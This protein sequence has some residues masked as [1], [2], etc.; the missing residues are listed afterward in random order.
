MVYTTSPAH[1][2]SPRPTYH[3]CAGDILTPYL[4]APHSTS[5]FSSSSDPDV[6]S[7]T[8][9]PFSWAARGRLA[10]G[11]GDFL[12]RLHPLLAFPEKTRVT[13]FPL[14]HLTHM[15]GCFL[16]QSCGVKSFCSLRTPH[17]R[18]R[19][20]HMTDRA[21]YHHPSSSTSAGVSVAK[22][23]CGMKKMSSP[24][25]FCNATLSPN[26]THKTSSAT[27]TSPISMKPNFSAG[28]LCK[29]CVC[30]CVCE[31]VCVCV[32][33]HPCI[34]AWTRNLHGTGDTNPG[35]S[36]VMRTWRLGVTTTLE[37]EAYVV[38]FLH[39]HTKLRSWRAAAGSHQ[40]IMMPPQH[41]RAYPV[42]PEHL[43][44]WQPPS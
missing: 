14:S 2:S 18:H 1:V 30:M 7:L 42:F 17:F 10:G 6:A 13:P 31:C 19:R 21:R 32:W 3:G 35:A 11:L 8:A 33:F 20:I 43:Q 4:A 5:S 38:D 27:I 9:L 28:P 39:R 24:A 16:L 12:T 34:R 29:M 26:G 15:A 41:Q 23:T 37:I 44:P 22:C 25:A 36:S 40:M